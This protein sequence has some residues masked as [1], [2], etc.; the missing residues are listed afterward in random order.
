MGSPFTC[1]KI[2]QRSS[3]NS[4][5]KSHVAPMNVEMWRAGRSCSETLT[6]LR[7]QASLGRRLMT[8]LGMGWHHFSARKDS[9]L[10]IISDMEIQFI[11][12]LQGENWRLGNFAHA[13]G[14]GRGREFLDKTIVLCPRFADRKQSQC[15]EPAARCNRVGPDFDGVPFAQFGIRCERDAA[16]HSDEMFDPFDG[17]YRSPLGLQKGMFN[18]LASQPNINFELRTPVYGVHILY[19]AVA[20]LDLEMLKYVASEIPLRNARV[21]ALGHTLLHVACMPADSLEVMRHSKEIYQSIHETRG[22]HPTNDPNIIGGGFD[23][24]YDV[25]DHSR[26]TAVDKYVWEQWNPRFRED[27]YSRQYSFALLGWVQER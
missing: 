24:V 22:L 21:T 3:F 27:G 2:M 6:S 16:V 25:K 1:S 23:K 4:G 17:N 14:R 19:F 15:I 8:G 5:R 13:M 20:R 9:P 26:Q 7:F 18:I 11:P 12:L 10:P